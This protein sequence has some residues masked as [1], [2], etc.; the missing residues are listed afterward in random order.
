MN[1]I[2]KKI[3]ETRKSKGLSQEELAEKS[4]INL[5]TLQR[6]ENNESEPRGTTLR[7]L[8]DALEMDLERLVSKDVSLKSNIG[9][10]VVDGLFLLALNF[11]LMGII[12]FLTLDSKANINSL[13]GAALLSMFLPFFIVFMTQRISGAERMFK[14]GFGY[15]LYFVLFTIKQGFI[16]GFI[17]GLFPCLLISLSVLYFGSYL[18]KRG[19]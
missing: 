16:K 19:D 12:G 5:R 9:K 13:F 11:I 3:A 15:L 7:L 8:C 4:K 1:T 14:F 17:T 18:I 2:A 6:I 10:I